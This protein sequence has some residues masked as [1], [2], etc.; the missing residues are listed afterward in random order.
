MSA[1]SI[2][3]FPGLNGVPENRLSRLSRSRTR[4][5]RYHAGSY[6]LSGS[7]PVETW[8]F[9]MP[10]RA[11]FV[12]EDREIA[13]KELEQLAAGQVN[14]SGL[15]MKSKRMGDSPRLGLPD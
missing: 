7:S 9:R 13:A 6:A 12:R 10:P 5:K 4:R 2:V 15:R 1:G 8:Y 11:F 3:R 14:W